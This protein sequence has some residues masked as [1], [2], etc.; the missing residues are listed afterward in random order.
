MIEEVARVTEVLTRA[1]ENHVPKIRRRTLPHPEID[2]E[3]KELTKEA[4]KT[5]IQMVNRINYLRNRRKLTQLRKNIRAKWEEK[6][7]E[8]WRDLVR[9]TDLEKDPSKFWK[10]IGKMTERK[11]RVWQET[12]KNEQ[13][14]KLKTDNEVERAFRRILTKTLQISEEENDDFC[15]E[16]EERVEE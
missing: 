13:R 14:E 16:T 15:E 3:T 10:E 11:K 9:R 4:R 5:K 12:F 1:I 6:R 2:E 8:M 7:R